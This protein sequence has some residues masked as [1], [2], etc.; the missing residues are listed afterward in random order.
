MDADAVRRHI[1]EAADRVPAAG[2]DRAKHL[3]ADEDG[4]AIVSANLDRR[5][6]GIPSGFH[7]NAARNEVGV[8]I[9]GFGQG[10]FPLGLLC[11]RVSFLKEKKNLALKALKE[12]MA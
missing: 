11:G 12:E 7:R 4:S 1:V 10:T 2:I 3:S 6:K 5:P 9:N 8:G